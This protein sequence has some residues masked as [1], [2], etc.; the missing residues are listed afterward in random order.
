MT[1]SDWIVPRA[2]QRLISALLALLISCQLLYLLQYSH[3]QL[4]TVTPSN[5]RSVETQLI[6]LKDTSTPTQTRI[7]QELVATKPNKSSP[8]KTPVPTLSI[9]PS[10][11]D[12]SNQAIQIT[13][14]ENPLP[15][16]TPN[17]V[18]EDPF[19]AESTKELRRDS[20]AIKQA[21]QDSKTAIQL[22]E[23]RS[24]KPRINDHQS[25]YER[26]QDNATQAKIPDC[27]QPTYIEKG[28]ILL[29]PVIAAKAL[30]GKCK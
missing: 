13:S 7:A 16:T 28:N 25:K 9:K 12:S 18:T 10:N 15:Q 4:R 11:T 6:L 8:N 30:L 26:F 24:G 5:S 20:A 1:N 22:L 14:P 21:Y 23:E 27:I 29:A 3:S 2:K 17:K 19:G